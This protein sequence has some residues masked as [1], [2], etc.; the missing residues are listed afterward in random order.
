MV[1]NASSRLQL[2]SSLKYAIE[3]GQFE[4]YYQPCV[5][6]ADKHM[7]AVEALLRW[8][9]P[10]LGMVPP[11]IFIPLAEEIGLI[12]SI[13]DWVLKTACTQGM[14]WISNGFAPIQIAV[15]I[16][17]VTFWDSALSSNIQNILTETGWQPER[18]CLEIT[19][20]ALSNQERSKS[21]LEELHA[22]GMR[23]AIDDFGVGY[24]S[25]SYLKHFPVHYLKIDRSF[26]T[27][28]VQDKSDAAIT[29]AIIALA[30]SLE[31]SVIAEGVE[32]AE[33]GEFL[34]AEGCDEAQ[35]YLFGKPMPAWKIEAWLGHAATLD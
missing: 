5:D 28:S 8:H 7:A 21:M 6:I 19:E 20:T 18:L 35:G 27:R 11:D 17:P 31:L 23:L 9:H 10:E 29:R 14:L 32:T 22:M 4:L 33:Q 25:L 16:S 26:I 1:V 3:R 24:S 15:N 2:S 13:T 30:K 34:R 12:G